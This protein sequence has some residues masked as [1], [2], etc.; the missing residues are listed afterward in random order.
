MTERPKELERLRILVSTA[1]L[2]HEAIFGMRRMVLE[3]GLDIGEADRLL[4]ESARIVTVRLPGL[5]TRVR[6]LGSR[7][8]EQSL[9]DPDAARATAEEIAAEYATVEGELNALAA[10]VDDIAARMHRLLGF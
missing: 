4:A 8:E 3:R 9:L 10:R 5:T 7:W 6:R 2:T 1:T